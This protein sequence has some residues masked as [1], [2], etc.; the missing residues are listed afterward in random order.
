MRRIQIQMATVVRMRAELLVPL[1]W[2]RASQ[3]MGSHLKGLLLVALPTAAASADKHVNKRRALS[4][5]ERLE[6]RICSY[7]AQHVRRSEIKT[8]CALISDSLDAE[9]KQS[10]CQ[11]NKP[12]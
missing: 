3:L 2:R 9:S 4:L 1:E 6:W 11:S 7:A 5:C 10:D 12:Q 8:E